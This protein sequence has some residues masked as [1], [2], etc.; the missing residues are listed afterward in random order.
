MKVTLAIFTAAFLLLTGISCTVAQS[1]EEGDAVVPENIDMHGEEGW[2]GVSVEDLT[3]ELAKKL[4]ADAREGV[5]VSRV[6]KE[7][8]AEK[9]GLRENDIIVAVN[10]HDISDR[11]DLVR[12][13]RSED[14]GTSVTLSVIRESKKQNLNAVLGE[15]PEPLPA[16]APVPENIPHPIF[17]SSES[18]T[19]GLKLRTLNEQLGEYFGAPN[20]RGVLVEEV[21]KGSKAADAGF[22]AGDVIIRVGRNTVEDLEDF[23]NALRHYDQGDTAQVEVMRKGSQLSLSLQL[24]GEDRDFHFRSRWLGPHWDHQS[25]EWNSQEFKNQMKE[26]GDQMRQFGKD[27]QHQMK[28]MKERIREELRHIEI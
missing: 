22:K 8:P 11:W 27:L 16:V 18:Q 26:F 10:K 24:A 7:S 20:S 14:P 17:M 15:N 5:V 23:H 2:L 4:K 21:R 12:R 3:P 6:Q 19:G 13:I 1:R 9:A 25:F 28:G